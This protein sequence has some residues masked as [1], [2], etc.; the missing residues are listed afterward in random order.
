MASAMAAASSSGSH[1]DLAVLIVSLLWLMLV[2]GG[3]ALSLD[4][5]AKS[6]PKAEAAVA[7][8]VKQA[9]A[10]DRTVPAALLRM[11]FH[12]CFVRVRNAN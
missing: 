9:M 1:L 12:D 4:Y 5:Y 6:C 7:A 8:A 2:G 10:R 3:E 11:H